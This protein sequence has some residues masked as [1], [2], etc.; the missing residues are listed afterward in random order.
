LVHRL[1]LLAAQEKH[2]RYYEKNYRLDG[3]DHHAMGE[4][5]NTLSWFDFDQSGDLKRSAIW[6]WQRRPASRG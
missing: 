1:Q 6:P 4:L 3:Y 2:V 5:A